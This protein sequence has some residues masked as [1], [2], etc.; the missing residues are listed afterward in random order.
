M[1]TPVAVPMNIHEASRSYEAWLGR[2]TSLVRTDLQLK[3]ARMRESPF[4]F[5]RATFYRWVQC[6]PDVC[7]RLLD[8]PRVLAVGDLHVENFG[9]WRDHEGR[10]IWGVNDVDEVCVLP[11][12]QDLVRLAASALL[13]IRTGA[14]AVSE[15]EACAAILKGYTASLARG[16]GPLVLEEAHPW[17]REIALNKLRDPA[18]FWT[19]LT[20]LRTATGQIPHDALRALFP[21]R[22][23]PYRVVRRVAGAGSLG[24]PRF[25]ALAEWRGGL[26]AREAK[27]LVPSASV[28]VRG[29]SS[30]RSQGA[31]LL[32]RAVRAPEPY[33][34]ICGAWIVRRLAPDCTR[35]ELVTLP[36]ERDELKLLH[37]MG[38]ETAN[39]HLGTA[40]EPILRD[41]KRRPGRWLARGATDMM[42]VLTRDW[43]DW[44]RRDG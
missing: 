27:A 40:R 37:A 11:Y 9:T 16:G 23:I 36:K 2:H 44:R 19:K 20:G 31:T 3:H 42:S 10:L 22:G 6:W 28:W 43:R 4:V 35:I 18:A 39:L 24:R 21:E 7:P 1:K 25:V 8:A 5:L 14:F 41:L 30:T 33:F 13:A 26:V 34:G 12:T 29:Q 15:R 17:L 32:G 38:W